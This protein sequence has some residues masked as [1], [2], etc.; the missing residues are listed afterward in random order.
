MEQHRN[1]IKCKW[2]LK[3]MKGTV[4]HSHRFL[5]LQTYFDIK[6]FQKLDQ[7]ERH[8]LG[9]KMYVFICHQQ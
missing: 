4:E 9:L 5:S 2:F 8:V 6:Q 7:I 3:A 1:T